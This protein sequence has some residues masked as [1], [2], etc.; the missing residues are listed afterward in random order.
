MTIIMK[1]ENY[2]KGLK[3]WIFKDSKVSEITKENLDNIIDSCSFFRNLGGYERVEKDYTCAGYVPV[4]LISI[5]PDR[6]TRT[7]RRF[8]YIIK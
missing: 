2:T 3:K 8:E 1:K 5:S 7:I 4:K 6:K